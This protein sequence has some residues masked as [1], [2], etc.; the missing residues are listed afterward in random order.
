[1]G[2][3]KPVEKT[4]SG[5]MHAIRNTIRYITRWVSRK[6]ATKPVHVPEYKRIRKTCVIDDTSFIGSGIKQSLR[7][8]QVDILYR[9]PS[10]MSIL[11]YYDV[12]IVDNQ[13]IGNSLYKSGQDFLT[14]YVPKHKGQIV[15]YHSGLS[16]HGK[17]LDILNSK[18]FYNFTKGR[19]PQK[20]VMHIDS[21]YELKKL[22]SNK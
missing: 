17:F 16:A 7:D 18:G 10:D 9:L 22:E 19:D 1:M 11:D 20:L 5:I 3:V 8:D 12:L 13:G 21:A 2:T 6:Q 14:H 4:S 15:V